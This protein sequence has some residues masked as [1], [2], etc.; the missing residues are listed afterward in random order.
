MVYFTLVRGREDKL[1]VWLPANRVKYD[2]MEKPYKTSDLANCQLTCLEIDTATLSTLLQV[3]EFSVAERNSEKGYY[4]YKFELKAGDA[5]QVKAIFY[6]RSNNEILL[7][8]IETSNPCN[9]D[10]SGK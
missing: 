4:R 5:K 3:A 2:I 10:E 7:E 9:C 6:S 8:S 1:T